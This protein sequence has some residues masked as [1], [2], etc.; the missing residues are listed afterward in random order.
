[1]QSDGG[2][3][4]VNEFHGWLSCLLSNFATV[5]P[6]SVLPR[7]VLVNT[8]FRLQGRALGARWWSGGFRSHNTSWFARRF[9]R[10]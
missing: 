6:K 10:G 1:M 7:N 5:P 4:P 2:L 3:A 8:L 9:R